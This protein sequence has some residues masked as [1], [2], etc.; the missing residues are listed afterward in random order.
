[1]QI[2]CIVLKL[3]ANQLPNYAKMA[4]YVRDATN[5]GNLIPF[6]SV[7]SQLTLFS[8]LSPVAIAQPQEWAS[9]GAGV[10]GAK[11]QSETALALFW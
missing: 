10:I 4:E 2:D 11:V 1:M 8:S 9:N 7:S 3:H 5:K 6:V